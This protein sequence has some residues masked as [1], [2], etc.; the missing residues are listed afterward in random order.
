MRGRCAALP[1]DP[2]QQR[3]RCAAV[4]APARFLPWRPAALGRRL[5]RRRIAAARGCDAALEVEP[6]RR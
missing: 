4:T 1:R 5:A 3:Y 6:A 2:A